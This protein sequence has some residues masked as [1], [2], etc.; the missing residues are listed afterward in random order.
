MCRLDIRMKLPSRSTRNF[1]TFSFQD[2]VMPKISLILSLLHLKIYPLN[3]SCKW[4]VVTMLDNNHCEKEYP[5]IIDIDSCSLHF[6]HGAFKT[7]VGATDWFLN[8][9]LKAMWKIF[10]DSTTRR[11]TYIKIYDVDEFPLR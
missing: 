7:G 4:S 5:K 8:E 2:V 6:L 11:D 9:V 1:L 10:D 3:V